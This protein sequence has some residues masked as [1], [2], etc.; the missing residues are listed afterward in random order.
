MSDK[1]WELFK[2]KVH[3]KSG[4]N[5]NDYKP[6]Q[7]QRRIGNMMSRHGA[8]S[9]VD[10]FLVSWRPTKSCIRISSIFLPLM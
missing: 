2:Q 6:A 10:F 1:D 8:G 7:M 9:Y 5:L 3:T 4:I